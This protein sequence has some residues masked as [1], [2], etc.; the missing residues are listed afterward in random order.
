[1]KHWLIALLIECSPLLNVELNETNVYSP[2]FFPPPFS[3]RTP[4]TN[5]LRKPTC[6]SWLALAHGRISL[7][8]RSQLAQV[9]PC[10]QGRMLH[11]ASYMQ[12]TDLP[13]RRDLLCRISFCLLFPFLFSFP[14]PLWFTILCHASRLLCLLL[15][16]IRH[17]E[18][19]NEHKT[20]HDMLAVI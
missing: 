1:M 19:R 2:S 6:H 11:V 16:L 20:W 10:I 4:L 15:T 5:C 3:F 18:T 7:L 9:A 8:K 17:L 13:D 14:F 12:P